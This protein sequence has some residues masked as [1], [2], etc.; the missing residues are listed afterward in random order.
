MRFQH[1]L[2]ITM[3]AILLREHNL[4]VE[5]ALWLRHKQ[6]NPNKRS[7]AVENRKELTDIDPLFW[8]CYETLTK[9]HSNPSSEYVFI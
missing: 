8:D 1:L 6:I 4:T 3:I 2:Q 7:I 9:Q 5:Q